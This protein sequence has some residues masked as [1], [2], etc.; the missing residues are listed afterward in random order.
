MSYLDQLNELMELGWDKN[1][2]SK[3]VYAE[4]FPEKYDLDDY[5]Q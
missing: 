3:D 5:E 4:F 1:S 2:A